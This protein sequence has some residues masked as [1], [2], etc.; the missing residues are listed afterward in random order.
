MRVICAAYCSSCMLW[1]GSKD[2]E[3]FDFDAL[4]LTLCGCN[5]N[6]CASMSTES[7]TTI[8]VKGQVTIPVAI[9]EELDLKPGDRL[10]FRLTKAGELIV[11]PRRQRSIFDQLDALTLP[12]IGRSSTQADID[13]A[14]AAEMAERERR[15]R[16]P[17]GR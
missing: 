6:I 3:A 4:L 2:V 7:E 8:T 15:V 1:V 13:E 10:R 17:K 14:V 5:T 11:E 16:R 9:R 12:S